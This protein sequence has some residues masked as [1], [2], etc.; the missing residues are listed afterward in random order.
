MIVGGAQENTLLTCRGL[1]ELG[2]R[3]ILFTGPSLGP[4]GSLLPEFIQTGCEIKEIPT[5][6]RNPNPRSEWQAYRAMKCELMAMRP[7]VVHTHSSKAGILGRLAA[8]RLRVPAV[9]HTVHGLPFHPYQNTA[10]N[11]AWILL[12]RYAARRCHKIVCVAEA[13]RTQAL[14]A[15]VGRPDQYSI[16]YSGM[17]IEQ[18]IHPKATR[19]TARQRL[20]IGPD[21]LV[22]GTIARLQPLKGHDDLLKIAGELFSRNKRV[23]FLWVGDGVYKQRFLRTIEQRGW[24]GRFTLT[25][26]VPPAEVAEILPAMDILAHPSYREGLP[27]AV[28]QGMLARLPTVVYNCDGAGEVCRPG[29]TG[30]LVEPGNSPDLLAAL[31]E[32]AEDSTRRENFGR[33][34]NGLAADLFDYRKMV[35][36]LD[37]L[38]RKVREEHEHQRI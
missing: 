13:M 8:W 27:R 18:Y 34:G 35:G 11:Q 38:Y 37:I 24:Q 3:V 15:G 28:V 30:I 32:M 10:I 23:H 6:V 1:R 22:I 20:G 19:Q 5:L 14:A 2:H 33:A 4:E 36:Q 17:E 7:D 16:A 26:L 9:V 21:A 12:E 25:G 29:Q 31:S